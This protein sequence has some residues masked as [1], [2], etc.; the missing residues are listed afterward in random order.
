MGPNLYSPAAFSKLFSESAKEQ[1]ILLV[2]EN[3]CFDDAGKRAV[4]SKM[5]RL[6]SDSSKK[7]IL[8]AFNDKQ[9]Q[10][11]QVANMEVTTQVTVETVESSPQ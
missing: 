2:I 5:N 9:K 8:K 4:L 3:P 7:R 6:F 10:T 11:A 1:V